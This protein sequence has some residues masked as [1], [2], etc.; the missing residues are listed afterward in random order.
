ML[1]MNKSDLNPSILNISYHQISFYLKANGWIHEKTVDAF[2]IYALNNGSQ[3]CKVLLA[4]D[5][6]SEDYKHN[7][8]SILLILRELQSPSLEDINW[9]IKKLCLDFVTQ[10]QSYE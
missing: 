4:R 1:K 9:Q 2:D 6:Q 7:L 8:V 5:D 10:E 3:S